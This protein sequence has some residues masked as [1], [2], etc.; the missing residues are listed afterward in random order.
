MKRRPRLAS[1]VLGV[2]ALACG[3]DR[4]VPSCVPGQTIACAG[5]AGCSGLQICGPDGTYGTCLCDRPAIV[6]AAPANAGGSMVDAPVDSAPPPPPDA[7]LDL[8]ALPGAPASCRDQ[9]IWSFEEFPTRFLGPRCGTAMCHGPSTV[10][11]PKNLDQPSRLYESLINRPGQIS[12][13]NDLFINTAD[14]LRSYLLATITPIGPDVICPSGGR[15]GL[16]MPNADRMPT[17]P[18]QR[19]TEGEITCFTWWVVEMAR[20]AGYTPPDAGV[21]DAF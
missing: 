12:C 6:D 3:D 7:S 20:R 17:I 1:L 21:P 19:L 9:G 8:P 15:G 5:P 11:P 4:P 14:P 18:G 10:F 16:R 2:M 13:R